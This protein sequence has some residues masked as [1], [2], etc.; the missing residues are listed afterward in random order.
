MMSSPNLSPQHPDEKEHYR[1]FY[2]WANAHGRSCEI[3][4][5]GLWLVVPSSRGQFKAFVWFSPT[6]CVVSIP[7]VD[8][9]DR[10][11]EVRPGQLTLIAHLNY[12]PGPYHFGVGPK[13]GEIRGYVSSFIPASGI[14]DVFIKN[15]I[16]AADSTVARYEKAM[17]DPEW[18]YGHSRDKHAPSQA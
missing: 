11:P 15:V 1:S 6:L 2:D 12:D 7:F 10:S 3:G 17:T 18:F 13:D 16:E 5:D 4:D 14:D 9:L 8:E